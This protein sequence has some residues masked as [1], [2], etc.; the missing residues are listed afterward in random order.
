MLVGRVAM[1]KIASY[2]RDPLPIW[3][4]VSANSDKGAPQD[5]EHAQNIFVDFSK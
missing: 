5:S 2:C 1:S 3:I 4:D